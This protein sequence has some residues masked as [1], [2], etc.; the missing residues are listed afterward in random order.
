MRRLRL[1]ELAL[2]VPACLIAAAGLLTLAAI[3]QSDPSGLLVALLAFGGLLLVASVALTVRWPNADQT[4]LPL[5]AALSAL[6]LYVIART[7]PDY[8]NRQIGWFALGTALFLLVVLGGDVVGFLRRYRYLGAL[9]AIGLLAYTVVFGVD[10]NDSG[11]K[12]WIRV[13]GTLYQP[14]EIVKILMVAF[15]AAYLDEK[16]ELLALGDWRIGRL[17]LPPL[18]YLLP[19]LIM[20]GA[21]LLLFLIQ[22][23][24]G[25]SF[26]FFGVFVA[27]LYAVSGRGLYV[28]VALLG[29][30]GASFLVYRLFSVARIRFDLWLNPWV[31]PEGRGY[32]II[33]A[34][35]AFANGGVAGTGPGHGAPGLI[36]AVYTDFP[37]AV[38]GEEFGLIGAL[39]VVAIYLILTVRGFRVALDL[40]DS[41]PGLL[42]M[43]LTTALGLQAL[44]ILAGNLKMV[45]LTGIT[46]PFIS[47]GGSSLITNFIILGLLTRLSARRG[48]AA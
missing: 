5:A 37:F 19:V 28:L 43:G 10:P 39:G 6:G 38:I 3:R 20:L 47:Y 11:T 9:L 46:L 24:L 40:G 8:L 16:R 4:F 14:A 31:D 27:M 26:L 1:T 21:C 17:R 32:Q 18:P 41:F 15:L 42:A 13:A 29:L 2:L 35:V 45:P 25:V 48:E 33:Q 44:L 12:L 7:E 36:P 34:L 22:K 30:G 23:D